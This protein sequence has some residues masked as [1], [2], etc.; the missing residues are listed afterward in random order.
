MHC[1][2]QAVQ[3]CLFPPNGG[4]DPHTTCS[5]ATNLFGTKLV[6]CSE[7]PRGYFG[8]GRSGCFDINEC[9]VMRNGGC[10]IHTTCH[11]F[12]GGYNCSD[13]LQSNA[14]CCARRPSYNLTGQTSGMKQ[15]H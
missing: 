9:T 11:N 7:C 15:K 4:C 8:S 1:E 2:P 14:L 10:D 6:Q 3:S 5:D 12:D 13:C